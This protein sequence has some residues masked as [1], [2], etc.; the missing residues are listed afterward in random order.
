MQRHWKLGCPRASVRTNFGCIINVVLLELFPEK[1]PT[2]WFY[3]RV[4]KPPPPR[5]GIT[6][7]LLYDPA[8]WRGVRGRRCGYRFRRKVLENL[9]LE[10]CL[11]QPDFGG[12]EAV[13]TKP[14][15]IPC[16]LNFE[17][18]V[19]PFVQIR[20]GTTSANS[21]RG[22]KGGSG[23]FANFSNRK[24]RQLHSG[25]F[26][27]LRTWS[28]SD[29]GLHNC[30]NT[31][32]FICWF[33]G[34]DAIRA[35]FEPPQQIST[36]VSSQARTVTGP[37]RCDW[38]FRRAEA[39]AVHYQQRCPP[40][41]TAPHARGRDRTVPPEGWPA[42]RHQRKDARELFLNERAMPSFH[43]VWSHGQPGARD[44]DSFCVIPPTG[45]EAGGE[46]KNLKVVRFKL[47]I[48]IFCMVQKN[49][50]FH[51]SHILTS[52]KKMDRV[53]FN[54]F[55]IFWTQ[56]FKK[57]PNQSASDSSI[58]VRNFFS[59][60][61]SNLVCIMQRNAIGSVVNVSFETFAMMYD[62][63]YSHEWGYSFFLNPSS[64]NS[65]TLRRFYINFP[66]YGPKYLSLIRWNKNRH[67]GNWRN[68]IETEFVY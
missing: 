16:T 5:L 61:L 18:I 3:G 39:P 14:D 8:P 57:F 13:E 45:Q 46:V 33:F 53:N 9:F 44:H 25:W 51:F 66:S 55:S 21:H 2:D 7:K 30:V 65:H 64:R 41:A 42:P 12:G 31:C 19:G 6:K 20:K 10:K 32:D 38:Q 43:K 48:C 26:V 11:G 49:G 59:G 63:W 56:R 24:I 36:D 52:E 34:G 17:R 50:I 47:Y 28:I 62:V 22:H 67:Y 15:M 29:D 68:G 58:C 35:W 40:P 23:L 60:F 37:C 27:K 4:E 54:I 1:K